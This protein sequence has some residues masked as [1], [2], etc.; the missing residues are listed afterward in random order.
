MN[1][2]GCRNVKTESVQ[3]K[4][5]D[6]TVMR[7]HLARPNEPGSFPGLLV[8]QEAFGVNAHIRSLTERLAEE[9]YVALAPELYHRT[10]QGF[11]S[12]YSDFASAMPHIKALTD[13]GLEADIAA[14]FDLLS[15]MPFVVQDNGPRIGAVG[16]CLG[17]RASFLAACARPLRCAVSFYGG[18]IAPTKTALLNNPGLL[19]RAPK[20]SGP[21]MFFWG[22]KDSHITRDH[23]RQ[24]ADALT[25]AQKKLVTVEFSAADHGFFCD[26]RASYDH[27]AAVQ[28]WP[29]MLNFLSLH[30]YREGHGDRK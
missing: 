12:P 20:M 15:G 14:A 22:G 1:R 2:T 28:A 11:D 10:A 18:G 9:G 27:E 16:F 29:M 21:M 8:F 4:V 24:I 19:D 30:L 6:G 26:E 13:A 17:G 5:S 7:A 25:I 3:I 23:H